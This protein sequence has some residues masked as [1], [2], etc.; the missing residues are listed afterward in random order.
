MTYPPPPELALLAYQFGHITKPELYH[1]LKLWC[2]KHPKQPNEET[3]EQA[4]S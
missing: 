2:E 1:M 3:D 4:V